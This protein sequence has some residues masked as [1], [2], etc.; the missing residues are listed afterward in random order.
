MSFKIVL[1]VS[2]PPSKFEKSICYALIE[3]E[4]SGLGLKLKS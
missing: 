2:A 4:I 3:L 1:Q